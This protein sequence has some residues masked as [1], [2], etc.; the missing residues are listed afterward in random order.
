MY[1][2]SSLKIPKLSSFWT[3]QYSLIKSLT[4][5][6]SLVSEDFQFHISLPTPLYNSIFS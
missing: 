4:E 5:I 1:D 6:L 3:G 2:N